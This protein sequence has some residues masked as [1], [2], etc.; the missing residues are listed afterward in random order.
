MPAKRW[1][2]II[3]GVKL[4]K[5]FDHG[6]SFF[7]KLERLF[8]QFVQREH[9]VED[10]GRILVG[11]SGGPDSVALLRLLMTV[12][13]HWHLEL[14][15]AHL[16]HGIRAA[17]DD[18]ADFVRDLCARWQIPLTIGRLNVPEFA[19]REKKGLEES[20]RE[21]RHQFLV[22]TARETASA[23]I[24]L[25]HH[26]GDQAET[27]LHRLIRGTGP[28]GLSAMRCRQG[29][30]IRPLLAFSRAQILEY[31]EQRRITF[32]R[33]ASNEDCRFTRNR[34]RHQVV[35]LLREFNP[36]IE[37]Q[38]GRMAA[39][40]AEEEEYW[41]GMT[42]RLLPQIGQR[43]AEGW[44]LALD[45]LQPLEAA[46]RRR[47]LRRFLEDLRAT[48]LGLSW[49]QFEMLEQLLVSENPHA[50]ANLGDCWAGRDYG[51]LWLL[52]KALPAFEPFALT[53]TVPG[54]VKVAGVGELEAQVSHHSDKRTAW[55]VEF[56]ADAVGDVL[57]VRSFEDGDRFHPFGMSGEKKL[58]DF[59]VDAGI[60]FWLRRKIPLMA[61]SG[62]IVWVAG[63]RRGA[64]FPVRSDSRRIL[65]VT[66]RPFEEFS[67][68]WNGGADLFGE[69]TIF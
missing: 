7:M 63:V 12:V 14:R 48:P 41:R 37:E 17:S 11:L 53:L 51:R 60:S 66:F 8:L 26:L 36:K 40:F 18:E 59:F 2:G 49:K 20:A 67:S 68:F 52:K 5:P 31:L 42:D 33:D 10:K 28:T 45:R 64:Q 62:T 54:R 9:L 22:Q 32:V 13:S 47:L 55:T 4:G 38:L 27:V 57:K 46:V 56:D 21:L 29:R 43:L 35:P 50:Q 23:R 58:K 24:A 25:G 19:R 1:M 34:L 3:G 6:Y 15:A 69:K 30:I 39:L 61:V 44:V 16:H 65:R